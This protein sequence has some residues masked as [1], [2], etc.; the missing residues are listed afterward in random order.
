[1]LELA[2]KI[3]EATVSGDVAFRRARCPSDF[4]MVH[5]D[6]WRRG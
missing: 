1:V 5:G 6:Q 4:V 2:K 3:E